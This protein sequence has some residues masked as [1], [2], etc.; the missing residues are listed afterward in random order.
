NKVLQTAPL[1]TWK[2]YL[3][4]RLADEFADAL[5]D[6]F[7]KEDFEFSKLLTGAKERKPRWKRVLQ[8]EESV[9]GELLG[10]LYVKE[11]FDST[12]KRRYEGLVE[13]IRS[14][15]KNR[16]E[17]L[18]WMSDS[19]KQKALTKLAAVKK[20]VGYPDKWKDFSAMQI[21]KESYVQNL[22]NAASW[23][24]NYQVN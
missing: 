7:G 4:Y 5:P 3:R 17:A 2:D 14:S 8:S 22:I 23:W 11:F 20:K 24:H 12:A 16:I 10:Q 13:A 21:G 18:S 6:A 1:D 15:L 9:M 19:T